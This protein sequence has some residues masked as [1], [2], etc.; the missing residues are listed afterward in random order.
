MW[1]GYVPVVR[2]LVAS[3]VYVTSCA[4]ALLLLLT[5]FALPGR[6]L[7]RQLVEEKNILFPVPPECLLMQ[8][9]AFYE[10]FDAKIALAL[11]RKVKQHSPDN[12][13]I[14]SSA[15]ALI[16]RCTAARKSKDGPVPYSANRSLYHTPVN[17]SVA[18]AL[19]LPLRAR[20]RIAG[21]RDD[22]GRLKAALRHE[23]L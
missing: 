4:C 10:R 12:E 18:A 15:K 21:K 2:H 14:G 20:D 3:F 19:P 13:D 9:A 1:K 11:A 6:L 8:A 23:H 22:C 7:C 5:L 17:A 16:K